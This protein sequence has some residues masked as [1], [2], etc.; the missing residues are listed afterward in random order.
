M[1][2]TENNRLLTDFMGLSVYPQ[3][4]LSNTLDVY[5]WNFLMSVV[6]KIRSTETHNLLS[7]YFGIKG[8]AHMDTIDEKILTLGVGELYNVCVDFVKFYNEQK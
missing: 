2:T 4:W 8:Y 7:G 6:E 3:N 1:K 5:S